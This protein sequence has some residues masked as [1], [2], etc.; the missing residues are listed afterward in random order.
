MSHGSQI[1][2]RWRIVFRTRAMG[3]EGIVAQ[4]GTVRGSAPLGIAAVCITSSPSKLLDSS[5]AGHRERPD[6]KCKYAKQESVGLI[7]GILDWGA[8]GLIHQCEV[9]ISWGQK[10]HR[11]VYS[12]ISMPPRRLGL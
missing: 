5:R 11:P 1:G 4:I 3:F 7:E 9:K 2:R 12:L 8:P 10:S 6:I